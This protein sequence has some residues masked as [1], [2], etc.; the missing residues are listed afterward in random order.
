MR[1]WPQESKQTLRF[2]AAAR[3]FLPQGLDCPAELEQQFQSHLRHEE[4]RQAL[5]VLQQIGDIHSG[6]DQEAN[7]WK[8]LF[9]A[10]QHMALPEHAAH[11]EERIRQAVAMRA[12]G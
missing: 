12:M 9:Y 7:F 4:L 8:E 6:Y 3:C 5:E 10:A 1:T 11:C 2:L